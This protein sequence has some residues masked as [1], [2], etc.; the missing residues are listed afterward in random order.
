MGAT[1]DTRLGLVVVPLVWVRLG[2]L[3]RRRLG[4]LPE[5]SVFYVGL[6]RVPQGQPGL[7]VYRAADCRLPLQRGGRVPRRGQWCG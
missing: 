3:H 6:C 1:L 7:L 5:H 4:W 2:R